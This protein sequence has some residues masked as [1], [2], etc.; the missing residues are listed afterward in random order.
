[1]IFKK[2]REYIRTQEA[3]HRKKSWEEEYNEL[4]AGGGFTKSEG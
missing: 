2:V 1:M 4:I 3:H